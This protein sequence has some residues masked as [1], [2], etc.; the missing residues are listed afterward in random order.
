MASTGR[1]IEEQLAVLLAGVA[2]EIPKGGLRGTL[3]RAIKENRPLRVKLGADPS[4]PHLH[5]GHTVVLRKLRQF[6]DLGHAV[7]FLIG[8][9][10]GMIGDP[11]GRSTTRP[12]LTPDQIQANARTYTDQVFKILDPAKT[13]IRFNSEW[14]GKLT[15]SDV[16]TWSAKLTV[17][18]ILERDDFRKRYEAGQPIHLHEFLYPLVQGYDSVVLKSD[19]E[20]CGT[21]QIFNCHVGRALQ[22]ADGQPPET[23]LAMPLLEGLD[24][25]KKM[26]KSL[27]NAVGITEVPGEMYGKVLSIPD[28]LTEKYFTLLLD[29]SPPAE[30]S[31]RD[32]KHA[33]AR[34]I[35]TAYHGAAAAS[36]A[37]DH[38]EKV[39]VKGEAPDDVPEVSV[40]AG[41]IRLTVLL[42]TAGLAK[43]GNEAATLVE[44]G[45]VELNGTAI[46]DIKAEVTPAAGDLLKIGKR[47]FARIRLTG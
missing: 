43:S 9:F 30:L 7:D 36:A 16:I 44:Q 26:S 31:P 1:P 4:A 10:T 33:L 20:M 29:T 37:A 39:I 41:K 6:Q 32:A 25:V 40:P 46:R 5:L 38:F 15:F 42:K 19:V 34:A 18:R 45:A 8:D 21:D 11:T 28:A 47:R 3:A 12:A 2:E 17:A 27:G 23:I 14:C 22:E 24:G 13:T 35:V